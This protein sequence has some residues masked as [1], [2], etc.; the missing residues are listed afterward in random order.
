MSVGHGWEWLHIASQ[1]V[2]HAILLGL[3]VGL[4]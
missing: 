3:Q 2:V 4:P 1:I